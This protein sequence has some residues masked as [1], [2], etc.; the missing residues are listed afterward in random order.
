MGTIHVAFGGA[1]GAGAPVYPPAPRKSEA[2]TSSAS[3]ASTTNT[4][5]GGEYA[6]IVSVDANVYLAVGSSPTALAS[7]AGM[8][9]CLSGNT[10]DLG[11][12]K[13]GDKVAVINV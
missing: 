9:V 8:H 2:V 5:N 1:M 6:R 4:A 10:L 12:L 7:G 11:P 3:S 13:D